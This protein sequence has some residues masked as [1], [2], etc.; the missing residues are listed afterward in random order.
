MYTDLAGEEGTPSDQD[1]DLDR[2]AHAGKVTTP[3][4]LTLN[5]STGQ[6]MPAA[7]TDKALTFRICTIGCPAFNAHNIAL[8]G[9]GRS[10]GVTDEGHAVPQCFLTPGRL[11]CRWIKKDLSPAAQTGLLRRSRSGICGDAVSPAVRTNAGFVYSYTV[12]RHCC[13]SA[14]G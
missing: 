3:Q 4:I 2:P 10:K 11:T 13:S 7:S 1:L 8:I 12:E 14:Q 5:G 6:H 9:H